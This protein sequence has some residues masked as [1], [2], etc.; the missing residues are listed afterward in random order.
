MAKN[1][2]VVVNLVDAVAKTVGKKW[3][4]CEALRLL[5][6]EAECKGCRRIESRRSSRAGKTGLRMY[7]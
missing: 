7:N 6:K 3:V 1:I 5:Y 4:A 2:A